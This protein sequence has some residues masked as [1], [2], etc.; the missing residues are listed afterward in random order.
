MPSHLNLC[1]LPVI[2]SSMKKKQRQKLLAQVDKNGHIIGPVE[3]SESHKKGTLHKGFSTILQ[4]K[5]DF[6]LQ[7]RK[8]RMFDGMFD[9]SYSSHQTY[10]RNRLEDDNVAVLK[11]LKRKWRL[12][13]K[14]IIG[15]PKNIG[16]IYFRAKDEKGKHI[17]HEMQEQYII[18]LK[19]LPKINEN[20]MYGYSLVPLEK[21]QNKRSKIY[22]QLTPWSKKTVE[23]L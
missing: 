12:D 18:K 19:K 21:L 23:L 3:K 6:V 14:D 15:Q 1:L 20:Y 4:Y 2:L 22:S 10:I 5:N 9:L 11:T 8:H 7:H 17:E 16:V 13:R